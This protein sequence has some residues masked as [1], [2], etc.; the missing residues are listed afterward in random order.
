MNK[1]KNDI[2]DT[3][4]Q[5]LDALR[6][7]VENSADNLKPKAEELLTKVKDSVSDFYNTNKEKLGQAEDYIEES[8]GVVNKAIRK[9]PLSAILIAAGIGY[10]F[11]KIK[12]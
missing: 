2:T 6:N 10:L 8:L 3:G 1:F 11:S 9:Q 5:S 12:K 7:K 4:E